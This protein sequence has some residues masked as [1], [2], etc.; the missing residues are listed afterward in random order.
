MKF[1]SKIN[2]LSAEVDVFCEWIDECQ[3]VNDP[4]SKP[5]DNDVGDEED[6]EE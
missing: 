6:D 2:H 3:R 5:I 4:N 1:S